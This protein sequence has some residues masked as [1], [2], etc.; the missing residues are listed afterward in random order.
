MQGKANIAGVL[1]NKVTMQ[2]TTDKIKEFI[3]EDR[4]HCVFTP[5]AEIVMA[6][7]RDPNLMQILNSSDLLLA[8]GAGVILASKILK[9]GIPEKVSGVDLVKNLFILSE[10]EHFKFFIYG[11]KPG[12]A[13][14]AADNI[15]K[16]FPGAIIAGF[17]HGY[18]KLEEENEIIEQINASGADI[19]L[20]ALGVPKQEKWIYSNIHKLKTRVC[21]GI[22]G[23]IDIFAGVTKKTPEFMRRNGL[24]WLH[25]LYKEPKR[26]KRMLDLPKFVMLV[27]AIRLKLK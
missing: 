26:Y 20:V 3:K 7:Y 6:A 9:Q 27:L 21:M 23:S 11:G 5:N 16:D 10:K 18:N 8:D 1:V 2:E 14:K 15:S 19:L 13:Q 22:G 4:V 24:E 17:R 25:R 12:V